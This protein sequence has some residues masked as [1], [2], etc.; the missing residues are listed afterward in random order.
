MKSRKKIWALS[1]ALLVAASTLAIAQSVTQFIGA[2]SHVIGVVTAI[3]PGG[4]TQAVTLNDKIVQDE[5]LTTGADGGVHLV[6]LDETVLR[7]GENS[8]L[9]IDA[10][11]YDPSTKE[12][13]NALEF[14]IGAFRFITGK[15]A[16]KGISMKLPTGILGVRG[17]D[18]E[19]IVDNSGDILIGVNKGKGVYTS[20]ITG[21]TIEIPA[22]MQAVIN[23]LGITLSP[24]SG[25]SLSNDTALADPEP[26]NE[27]P[28]LQEIIGVPPQI[29]QP[30]S[31]TMPPVD[32]HPPQMPP[33]MHQY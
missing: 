31:P 2:A 18:L 15:M 21:Q 33:Q 11:I 9:T 24:W 20:P 7:M 23:I 19:V 12:G 30:M 29:I 16:K 28:N 1:A 5:T 25:G 10:F 17:T 14:N 32:I 8:Q 22:G 4:K 13:I 6:F 26:G 3:H 27:R